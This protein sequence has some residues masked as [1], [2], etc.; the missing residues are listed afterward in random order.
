M[1]VLF[2]LATLTLFLTMD[3]FVQRSRTRKAAQQVTERLL[4]LGQ[5]F[6]QVPDGVRLRTN[7][8]WSK[9]DA[10]GIV[11]IGLDEFLA[12]FLGAVENISIP[13]AGAAVDPST[14]S[15]TLQD[16]EKAIALSSPVNGKV[17]AIN[18]DLLRSPALAAMD[19]YGRGW[20]IKVQA[21]KSNAGMIGAEAIQ[22]LREQT[23]AAR[24]FFSMREGH[25]AYALAQD[26]G[27]PV[28]GLMKQFDAGAWREFQ[29]SFLEFENGAEE[30]VSLRSNQ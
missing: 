18:H 23:E 5:A 14:K 12:K 6:Q 4:A 27:E 30:R 29:N 2:V 10:H 9:A 17:V 3:H 11:T 15:I 28:A 21:E 26:G 8:T 24:D 19:P 20:L 25:G 22:W 7:H 16:G 1:T 13:A